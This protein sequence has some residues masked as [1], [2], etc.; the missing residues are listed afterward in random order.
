MKI[1]RHI[2]K[3][4]EGELMNYAMNKKALAK[5]K[6]EIYSQQKTIDYTAIPQ[7][8]VYGSSPVERTTMFL[9]SQKSII[10]LDN[11]VNAIEDVLGELP[12]EYCQLIQLRYFKLFSIDR[13]AMEMNICVRN[14]YNWRD[15]AMYYF[16]LRFGLI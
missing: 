3:Y 4:I 2:Q 15:K 8:T 14:F 9:L 13:V 10:C 11:S 7:Q 6:Q 16:A 1:P 5:A 12:D